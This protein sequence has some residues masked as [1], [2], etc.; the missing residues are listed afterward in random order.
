[1]TFVP[2]A[3]GL[4][5]HRGMVPDEEGRPLSA[6]AQNRRLIESIS[7]ACCV[8]HLFSSHATTASQRSL[9]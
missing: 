5:A 2:P 8:M 6:A 7:R 9:L 4:C 1:M 3:C